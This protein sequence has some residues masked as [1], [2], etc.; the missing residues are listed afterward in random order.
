MMALARIIAMYW[1]VQFA[2][3]R[4]SSRMF[5]CPF[6]YTR[7]CR[8]STMYLRMTYIGTAAS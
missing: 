6:A 4:K 1:V 7:D 5:L 2:T 8:Y 3:K